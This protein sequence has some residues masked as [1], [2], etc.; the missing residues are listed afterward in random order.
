M[1]RLDRVPGVKEVAQVA[2][3]IGREFAYPLLAA[4]S[5][6]PEAEL[7]A[8]L[9]RLA[10][11]RAGLR[12]AASRPRRA[13]RSST[14]WCATPPTRACSRRGGRSCTPAIAR[15]L[16]E[17]FPETADAEPELLAR[18]CAE[19]GLAEQAV[20]Y[21]QRAGQR[22]LARSAM[23]GGGRAP[24]PGSGGTGGPARRSRAAAARARP[25]A[26]AG[27]GVDRRQGLRGAGDGPRLRPGPRAVPRAGRRPG[28]LPGPLRALH[29]PLPARRAGRGARGRAGA[30]ALAEERGDAAARVTGHRIVGSALY[31][32]GRLAE[33]RAHLEKGLA[34][35]DPGGTA[36]RPSSTPSTR[37]W[38]ACS[39]SPPVSSLGYPEQARAENE[40]P[41][42]P[43]SS[44]IH[45]TAVSLAACI[46][47]QLL[48]TGQRPAQAEATI[49]LATEQGF[50]L[51]RAVGTVV[52]GWSQAR[53]TGGGDRGDPPGLGRLWGHG[54]RE[55][56]RPTSWAC[57]PR[58]TGGRAGPAGLSLVDA[59]DRVGGRA[60]A[61]SRPT[62]TG[63]KGSCCWS[64]RA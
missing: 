44:P 54:G 36:A 45:T 38:S 32:L 60:A 16:E 62:C 8:A 3:C 11:G 50:P 52:H 29:R 14:R 33:S 30:A 18:H 9:D 53:R 49:A 43:A 24:E 39:G 20:D 7:R 51:Y 17:R 56:G 19:A 31:H 48:R 1:A 41:A 63:S 64:R 37:A 61:G 34:L 5:P 42:M 46:L 55:C 57:S 27:P 4:V 6:V 47:H 21:W 28:A 26:R 12:A 40:A 25:A 15:V 23:A 59:L 58:R 13:T 2:A 10:R 35:Y 22:A